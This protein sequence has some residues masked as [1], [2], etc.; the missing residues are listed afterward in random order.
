MISRSAVSGSRRLGVTRVLRG[1]CRAGE[2]SE[3][4]I[5][6]GRRITRD[7]DILAGFEN[8]DPDGTRHAAMVS[9][10][11]TGNWWPIGSEGIAFPGGARLWWCVPSPSRRASGRQADDLDLSAIGPDNVRRTVPRYDPRVTV[12]RSGYVIRG[13]AKPLFR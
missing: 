5:H 4:G 13:A 3:T 7:A 1:I 8:P 2:G 10:R 12:R 9:K 6:K 11:A